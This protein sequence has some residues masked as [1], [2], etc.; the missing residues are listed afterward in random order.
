MIN[1]ANK[2]VKITKVTDTK[3][4]GKHPMGIFA[5]SERI[6]TVLH[7]LV[8]GA[9]FYMATDK[10]G[11]RTSPVT[12][13]NDDMTFNTENSVYKIE[14]LEDEQ[15]PSLDNKDLPKPIP[16]RLYLHYKGGI[17]D[18]LHLAKHTTSGEEVVVYKSVHYGTYYAR[19]LAEWF[20]VVVTK[21]QN[22]GHREVKRFEIYNG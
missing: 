16:G 6:G 3:F 9:C 17:Y 13:I 11:F 15:K 21:E 22:N 19:P 20:D 2:K 12:S 14:L 7:N 4:D 5:G 1:L 8:T 18:V 10:G